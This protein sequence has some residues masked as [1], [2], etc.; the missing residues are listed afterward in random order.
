MGGDPSSTGSSSVTG[1]FSQGGRSFCGKTF[2]R[3]RGFNLGRVY[4]NRG[5]DLGIVSSGRNVG[6]GRTR[7]GPGGGSGHVHLDEDYLDRVVSG[8]LVVSSISRGKEEFNL[9]NKKL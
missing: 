5:G 9:F 4:T 6:T 3:T 1:M 8:S 2:V 7:S